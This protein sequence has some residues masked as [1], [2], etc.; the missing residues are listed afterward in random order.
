MF[1]ALCGEGLHRKGLQ[2]EEKISEETFPSHGAQFC[3]TRAYDKWLEAFHPKYRK[4]TSLPLPPRGDNMT[5]NEPSESPLNLP[6]RPVHDGVDDNDDC[7]FKYIRTK[8]PAVAD[9]PPVEGDLLPT[10]QTLNVVEDVQG[11]D[12]GHQRS[13]YG[14]FGDMSA[15]HAGFKN[16]IK[17]KSKQIE[18][19][20]EDLCLVG[21]K[22]VDLKKE[23][24]MDLESKKR[25]LGILKIIF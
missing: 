17:E 19:T 22:M 20:S 14:D 15:C 5:T 4:E 1:M 9:G 13:C 8:E 2:L 23:M 24:K 18:A 10:N 25:E 21:I 11:H 16:L 3:T 6:P 12:L 7:N